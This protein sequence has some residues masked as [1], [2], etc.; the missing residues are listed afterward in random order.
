MASF[1]GKTAALSFSIQ[2]PEFS[3]THTWLPLGMMRTKDFEFTTDTVDTTA[4]STANSAKTVLA[5]RRSASFSGDGVSY[6]DAAY[7]QRTL[8]NHYHNPGS[9]TGNRPEI[10]FKLAYASGESYTGPFVITSLSQAAPEA[11]V[12]T[13]SLSATSNGHVAYDDGIA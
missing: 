12:C 10:W 6:D 3:G 1:D 2:P 13:F 5:T 11:D 7:N 4:D 9:V 8:K